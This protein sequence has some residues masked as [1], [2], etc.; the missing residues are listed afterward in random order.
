M[1]Q[2]SANQ[3]AN[4]VAISTRQFVF[5][6][7]VV[8][9]SYGHFVYV[10]VAMLAA[11]RDAWAALVVGCLVGGGLLF[12]QFRLAA[13]H[14]GQ[15]LVNILQKTWGRLF[16][17]CLSALLIAFFLAVAT[18]TLKEVMSFL[19]M[20]YPRTPPVLFM[21]C[22]FAAVVSV[23][24]GGVEVAFRMIEL[25]L[26]SLV[27]IGLLATGLTLQYKEPAY[28]LPLLQHPPQ[29]IWQGSLPFISMFGELVVFTMFTKHLTSIDRLPKRGLWL[30]LLLFLMFVGPTIGPIMMFGER[31]A[32]LFA[33]PTYA[34]IQ[35]ID[36]SDVL[37][38]L[39]IL[40]LLLWVFGSFFRLAVFMLAAVEALGDLTHPPRSSLFA[41]PVC[42]FTV[43][44]GC[45]LLGSSRDEIHQFLLQAYPVIPVFFGIII[46][47]VTCMV[48]W[49]RQ[50]RTASGS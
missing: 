49:I 24:R 44:L 35:Y 26:P 1:K 18:L 31:G 33:Y 45:G 23:V 39:D 6:M 48:A 43:G 9:I 11:G 30:G 16:G 42:I 2:Q 7:L 34:E 19:G 50:R 3:H 41:I 38:R 13:Q 14:P 25:V 8:A 5:M 36:L 20:V 21:I 10:H 32:Q 40:G 47:A 12:L 22:E 15:S 29:Q 4:K 17:G 28:L 46:I 37:D 27:I